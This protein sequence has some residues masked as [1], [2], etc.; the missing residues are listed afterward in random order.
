GRTVVVDEAP[1]TD[2]PPVAMRQRTADEHGPRTAQRHLAG[3]EQL[4]FGMPIGHRGTATAAQLRWV[5]LQDAHVTTVR[6]A[7]RPHRPS[8]P[9]RAR[10]SPGPPRLEPASRR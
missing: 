7:A 2:H 4:G 3:F 10:S 1:G 9:A 5:T 8:V 6:F